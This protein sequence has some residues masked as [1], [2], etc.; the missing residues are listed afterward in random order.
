MI[1]MT[2]YKYFYYAIPSSRKTLYIW[3]VLETS[4]D[5]IKLIFR[6][7]TKYPSLKSKLATENPNHPLIIEEKAGSLSSL[8]SPFNIDEHEET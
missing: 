2:Q 8:F 6:G 5:T 3:E 1:C 4:K 7:E